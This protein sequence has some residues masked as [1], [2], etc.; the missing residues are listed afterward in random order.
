VFRSTTLLGTVAEPA[1]ELQVN[2]HTGV[3][4][5][6]HKDGSVRRVELL[7]GPSVV[8]SLTTDAVLT[9]WDPVS[10]DELARS[11]AGLVAIHGRQVAQTIRVGAHPHDVVVDPHSHRL[12]AI[13]GVT[14]TVMR[15]SP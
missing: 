6:E 4:Y 12:V 2:Q 9:G 14:L 10:G 3:A 13:S 5:A 15:T 1:E 8:T 11:A 7:N